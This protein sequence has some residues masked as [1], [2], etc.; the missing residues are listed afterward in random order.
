MSVILDLMPLFG[1]G[2]HDAIFPK[3][4]RILLLLAVMLCMNMSVVQA[5]YCPF[6]LDCN[7]MQLLSSKIQL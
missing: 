6:M 4:T 1:F 5:L 7:F 2:L 3:L